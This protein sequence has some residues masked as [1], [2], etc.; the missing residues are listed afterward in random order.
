MCQMLFESPSAERWTVIWPWEQRHELRAVGLMGFFRLSEDAAKKVVCDC[1]G[2][3]WGDLAGLGFY[4]V[5][6]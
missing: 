4:T 2:R 1:Y 6:I 5:R 3:T